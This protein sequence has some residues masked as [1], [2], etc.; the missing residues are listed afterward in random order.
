MPDNVAVPIIINV[1]NILWAFAQVMLQ[2]SPE[3]DID[4][5]VPRAVGS[6]LRGV[7]WNTRLQLHSIQEGVLLLMCERVWSRQWC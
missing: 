1:I 7:A 2:L 3:Q 6:A 4:N 5:F